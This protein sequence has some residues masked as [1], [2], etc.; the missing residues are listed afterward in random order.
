MPIIPNPSIDGVFVKLN[1]QERKPLKCVLV[2]IWN[3]LHRLCFG[4]L[5]LEWWHHLK[6]V[7]ALKGRAWLAEEGY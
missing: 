6:A 7:G 2:W 3:I 1:D 4:I 5:V